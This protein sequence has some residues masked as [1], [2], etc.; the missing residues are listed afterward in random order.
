MSEGFLYVGFDAT[1]MFKIGITKDRKKRFYQL[2]TANPT[3]LYLF[4]FRVDDPKNIE[5]SL[6]TRFDNWHYGG[7]WYTIG[8]EELKWIYDE[9]TGSSTDYGL[10]KFEKIVNLVKVEKI[11]KTI[12]R[13]GAEGMEMFYE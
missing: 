10:D 1:G 2:R 4:V 13:S 12:S 6:H 8:A 3:F 5:M 9:F 7:E 11:A